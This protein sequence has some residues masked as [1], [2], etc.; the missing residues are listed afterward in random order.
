MILLAYFL[1]SQE[2]EREREGWQWQWQWKP[3]RRV[4]LLLLDALKT[5]L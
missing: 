5:R 2:G 3:L 4:L 1:A